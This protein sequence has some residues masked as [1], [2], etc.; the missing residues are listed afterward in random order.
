MIRKRVVRT[1]VALGLVAS[2]AYLMA[3]GT[4]ACGSLAGE[5]ALSAVDFCF[6]FDCTN[7]AVGG[8]IDPCGTVGV[9]PDDADSDSAIIGGPFFAD[10]VNIE[11]EG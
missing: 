8:L 7:G 4:M 6:M 3:G 9:D 10:C 11:E 2:G 5:S 1:L